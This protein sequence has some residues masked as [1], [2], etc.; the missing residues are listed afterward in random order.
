MNY[1]KGCILH[2]INS[3]IK[4]MYKFSLCSTKKHS[5]ERR[6]RYII[7]MTIRGKPKIAVR[8]AFPALEAIDDKSV[9]RKEK[10]IAPSSITTKNKGKF[11]IGVPNTIAKRETLRMVITSIKMTL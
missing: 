1:A 2:L 11:L 5:L 10:A 3:K 9:K 8:E 4:F 7:R 6:I